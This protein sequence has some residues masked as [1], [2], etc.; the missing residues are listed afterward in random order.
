MNT[1]P[2]TIDDIVVPYT[3]VGGNDQGSR[4]PAKWP[5]TALVL[6]RGGRYHRAQLIEQ[7]T[8][9]GFA[10]ILCIEHGLAGPDLESQCRLCPG[11]RFMILAEDRGTGVDINLGIREARSPFVFVLWSDLSLL[12]FL[13]SSMNEALGRHALCTVPLLRN[14]RG[15]VVPSLAMP[16]E[17]ENNLKILPI[18][19]SQD[20]MASFF[21]HEYIGIYQRERFIQSQGFDPGIRNPFWQ[22]MDWG[23]RAWLWGESIRCLP[24]VRL[25][26]NTEPESEDTTPDADYTRF[27]LK[28]LL[29][30]FTGDQAVLPRGRFP[31]FARLSSAG[32]WADWQ[33]F[34]AVRAW[35][36]TNAYR[37]KHDARYITS[38][39]QTKGGI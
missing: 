35:V 11:L 1:I 21:P 7:L 14:L 19:P 28:N 12:P 8:R 22:K 36:R 38:V 26:Q 16:A 37:F 4:G 10:E 24:E 15:E 34:R 31:A 23:C 33:Y 39:W 20:N 2:T 18:M 27:Y 17:Q 30:R 29:P 25:Q 3:V 13:E 9:Q 6:N 5:V 32:W